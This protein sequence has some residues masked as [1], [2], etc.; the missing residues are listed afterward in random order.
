M[1]HH[2][3]PLDGGNAKQESQHGAFPGT[4]LGLENVRLS[5]PQFL[6]PHWSPVQ[7]GGCTAIYLAFDSIKL[8]EKPAPVA[9]FWKAFGAFG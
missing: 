9:P 4:S 5:A 1:A 2:G 6:S 3:T 7:N 8:H